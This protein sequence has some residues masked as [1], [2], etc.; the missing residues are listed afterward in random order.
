MNQYENTSLVKI[1]NVNQRSDL[2]FYLGKR[3][4]L[5]PAMPGHCPLAPS[6]GREASCLSS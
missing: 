6:P 3:C 1:E 2:D 5:T 4:A